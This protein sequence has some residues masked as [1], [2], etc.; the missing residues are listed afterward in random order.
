M[1]PIST[2]GGPPGGHNPPGRIRRPRCT[3]VGAALLDPPPVPIFWYISHFDLE[4]IR[5]GLLRRS[6]ADLRRNLGRS[7]FA[8]RWSDSAEGTSLPEGEIIVLVITS[9]PLIFGRV[10]SVNIFNNTISSQTLVHLL[11]LIFVPKPQIGTCG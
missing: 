9:N 1:Q 2:R 5:R 4:K 11:C 6:A 10:I 7:T 3:L 8:L